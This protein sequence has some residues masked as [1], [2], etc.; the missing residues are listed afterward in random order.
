MLLQNCY[1]DCVSAMVDLF[2]GGKFPAWLAVLTTFGVIV[3][4]FF[5][6]GWIISLSVESM[7]ME[8]EKWARRYEEIIVYIVDFAHQQ[9]M[10]LTETDINNAVTQFVIDNVVNPAT[11]IIPFVVLYTLLTLGFLIFVMVSP[12]T[13]FGDVDALEPSELDDCSCSD[14]DQ[15]NITSAVFNAQA[16]VLAADDDDEDDGLL[17]EHR[18]S[19]PPPVVEPNPLSRSMRTRS[20]LFPRDMVRE[21]TMSARPGRRS[22]LRASKSSLAFPPVADSSHDWRP[23]HR[24]HNDLEDLADSSA[25][26]SPYGRQSRDGAVA[27][28]AGVPVSPNTKRSMGELAFKDGGRL[29]SESEEDHSQR[30]GGKISMD[31]LRR[32]HEGM[33]AQIRKLSLQEELEVVE[34]GVVPESPSRVDRGRRASASEAELVS[35]ARAASDVVKA[36]PVVR[37]RAGTTAGE[38]LVPSKG[39]LLPQPK[40]PSPVVKGKTSKHAKLKPPRGRGGSKLLDRVN[41]GANRVLEVVGLAG[42]DG[43]T[44]E[45]DYDSADDIS[46]SEFRH[47]SPHITGQWPPGMPQDVPRAD[48][49]PQVDPVLLA[50]TRKR[51][52]LWAKKQRQRGRYY[53]SAEATAVMLHQKAQS[54]V[55]RY[56]VVHTWLSAATGVAVG[57]S[58]WVINCPT[59]ALFGLSAF[60]LNFIPSVG[61]WIAMVLPIPFILF[62]PDS[63]LTTLVL[64]IVLPGFMQILLGN[65]V[66]PALLG[67]LCNVDPI[68]ILVSILLFGYVWGIAGMVLAVPI[69]VIIKLVFKQMAHPIPRYIAGVIVGNLYRYRTRLDRDVRRRL[70]Y[71]RLLRIAEHASKLSS[72]PHKQPDVVRKTAWA[73]PL[74]GGGFDEKHLA[75]TNK[76]DLPPSALRRPTDP[77]HRV[78]IPV[79]ELSHLSALP[80]RLPPLETSA[81][82]EL[83]LRPTVATPLGGHSSSLFDPG[84][85]I[86]T[87]MERLRPADLAVAHAMQSGQSF[88]V[89]RLP[90]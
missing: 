73:V 38:P 67:K 61:S 56:I 9:G 36:E 3:A 52:R 12:T 13:F 37:A 77:S 15:E 27:H 47:M 88:P 89:R 50:N 68:V 44:S 64:A 35:G 66:E 45:E 33:E 48:S 29:R 19:Q 81:G 23:E 43:S 16:A 80:R 31:T 83:R 60:V 86:D 6:I 40:T 11:T 28:D 21:M 58:L 1:N 76:P 69:V 4:L 63:T 20:E 25:Q 85:T 84:L 65:F 53:D 59:P 78:S 70:R 30:Q 87:P 51:L 8:R 79:G 5:F 18:F 62:D 34:E 72:V 39:L 17:G 41:Q 7:L 54:R 49:G 42:G 46:L 10:S 57:L 22:R 90:E 32:W 74:V 71:E 82:S 24:S 26:H 2:L 75:G 55:T 14:D